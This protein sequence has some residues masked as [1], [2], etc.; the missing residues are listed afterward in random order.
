MSK[1]RA[2][3]FVADSSKRLPL[4]AQIGRKVG[5]GNSVEQIG[6]FFDKVEIAF[7]SGIEQEGLDAS[8]LEIDDHFG[9]QSSISLQGWVPLISPLYGLKVQIDDDRWLDALN[10]VLAGDLCDKSRIM[11]RVS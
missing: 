8:L 6:A 4:N 9:Y 5:Q 10:K 7:F 3:Q 2:V 1:F 11:G